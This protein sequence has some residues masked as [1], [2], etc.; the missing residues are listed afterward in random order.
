[1]RAHVVG[2]VTEDLVFSLS[3]LPREGETLIADGRVADIGGKGLNQALLL[4][5]AGCDVCFVSTVGG[6]AAGDHARVLVARDVPG[7]TLLKVTA[8][9]DQSI[10]CVAASGENHI[11]SSAFAAD[12]LTPEAALAAIGPIASGDAVRFTTADPRPHAVAFELDSLAP[13][14]RQYLERTGQLRGPPLVSEGTTWLI[15]LEDAPPGVYPFYCRA[16]DTRGQ[17]TVTA[18]D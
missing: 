3:R 6:D 16:H 2:N 10:I 9:T 8:P 15:I 12:A 7:A 11:V 14:V 4:S 17:L 18:A 13:P 1:M 5:R